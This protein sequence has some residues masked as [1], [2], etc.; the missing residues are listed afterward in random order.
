MDE[1]PIGNSG[2]TPGITRQ[3][4]RMGND[5]AR[6]VVAPKVV[7][8]INFIDSAQ[9]LEQLGPHDPSGEV[10]KDFMNKA[11]DLMGSSFC[12]DHINN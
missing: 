9:T 7:Q 8:A 6:N 2:F 12:D 11:C 4:E 5:F 3:E 10:Y 1:F